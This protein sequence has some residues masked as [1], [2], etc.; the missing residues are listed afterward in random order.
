[1]SSLADRLDG[2]DLQF[3]ELAGKYG[4]PGASLAISHGDEV[5]T[6]ATGVTSTRTGVEVDVNTVF[7]IG[8]ITKLFTAT[9]MMQLVEDGMVSLDEPIRTYLPELRLADLELLRQV[10]VRHLLAHTSGID[11]D[12]F[13][14]TGR[15]DDAI[16][17]YV[18]ACSG[19]GFLHLPGEHFSYC[20]AGYV[21]AGRII[22]KLRAKPFH[23]V[24]CERILKPL[25]MRE[26]GTLPEDAIL[27][28]AAVGHFPN[29][30]AT[31]PPIP[32]PIW[33]LP[34]SNAP[35]GS[36]AWATA[37]DLT[38]FGRAFLDSPAVALL[39]PPT[40][41]SMW[42][43]QADT[44]NAYNAVT[45]ALGF[46]LF[47]WGGR[48]VLGHDGGT[49]G[50]V[51]FVRVLPDERLVVALF[52]NGGLGGLFYRDL[53]DRIF[54]EFAG[55]SMPEPPQV[56]PAITVNAIRFAG[57]YRTLSSR[58][59]VE[60]SEGNA[61][62]V[63]SESLRFTM[64]AAEAQAMRFGPVSANT[65]RA[66]DGPGAAGGQLVTFVGADAAG[67]AKWIDWGARLVPRI[68]NA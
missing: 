31:Q 12:F 30:D 14:D 25:G 22:E 37:R 35:A 21:L 28:R 41:A 39:E 62:R 61:L 47:G 67:R 51:S 58:V 32:T 46:I 23:R 40:I 38:L 5:L 11:G 20:N 45:Q 6:V 63:T 34:H 52:T 57:T 29:P 43:K 53:Y 13:E 1:M 15:G 54:R 42:E 48:Q 64:R 17:R 59:T 56:D 65:F 19:L 66:L 36:S 33:M 26:S 60:P 3:P 55:V 24:L 4:V 16:E 18:L 44:S 50:Q 68:H 9:L 2:I 7:Q 8:S 27:H 49:I 10:T